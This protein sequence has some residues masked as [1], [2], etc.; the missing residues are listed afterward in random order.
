MPSKTCQCTP[1]CEEYDNCCH[2][3][4][5]CFTCQE[6]PYCTESIPCDVLCHGENTCPCTCGHIPTASP[7]FAPTSP[8]CNMDLE[9]DYC[10]SVPCEQICDPNACP[11]TCS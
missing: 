2:D 9:A 3:A 10:G 1:A 8:T 4:E 5:P 11:C 6:Q 7:S